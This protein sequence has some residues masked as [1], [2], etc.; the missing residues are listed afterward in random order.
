MKAEVTVTSFAAAT[1]KFPFSMC[2]WAIHSVVGTDDF[3]LVLKILHVYG[4]AHMRFHVY[5]GMDC[6]IHANFKLP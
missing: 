2:D 3:S 5:P 6:V 1:A 4:Q